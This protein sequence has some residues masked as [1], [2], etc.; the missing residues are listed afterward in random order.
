M[1]TRDKWK[2]SSFIRAVRYDSAIAYIVTALFTI[3]LL[4]LGAGLLYGTDVN[5]SGEK[6]L[7]E[8]ASILGNELHPSV[9]YLFLIGFW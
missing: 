5:I 3:S 2:G 4:V 8:F 1:V 9:Q 6:G 7:V